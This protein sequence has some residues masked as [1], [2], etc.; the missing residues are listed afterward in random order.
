[1]AKQ[2][3]ERFDKIPGVTVHREPSESKHVYQLYSI[4]LESTATRDAVID[5]LDAAGVSSRV[6]WEPPVHRTEF[7]KNETS[8]T[9]LPVTDDVASRILSLPIYTSLEDD[10]IDRI[11]DG[12]AKGTEGER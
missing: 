7:Y 5:S 2:L 4:L 9:D 6:Y 1:V 12:V 11:V 10:Q 3:S 8:A